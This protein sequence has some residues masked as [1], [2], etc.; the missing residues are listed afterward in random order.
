MFVFGLVS[1][2]FKVWSF[3][4]IHRSLL[5][6]QGFKNMA[7]QIINDN[8]FHLLL[9]VSLSPINAFKFIGTVIFLH[10]SSLNL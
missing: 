2:G 8:K 3:G 10:R 6:I 4:L 9:S 1:L 5:K 7:D